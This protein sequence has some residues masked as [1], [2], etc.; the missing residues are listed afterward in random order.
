MHSRPIKDLIAAA[1]VDHGALDFDDRGTG[2]APRRLPDWTRAQLP[3]PMDV[4]VRMPSG[5]RLRFATDSTGVGISFLATTWAMPGRERRP[6]VFNLET[7]GTLLRAEST[8]GNAIVVK[9]ETPGGFDLVRGES[10]T[11]LFDG[12]PSG[13][14]TCELWLPHNALVE[15]RALVV[16]DGAAITAAPADGRR[17]WVHY[18]SSISHCME[19]SEPAGTWPAVAARLADVSLRN[20][21]FGGQCH[22]DQFVART[23]RDLQ[24]VDIVSIKTGINI[25]N[26]DSMRE[27]VFTPALHGF[28]DTIRERKPEVPI[29]VISPIYCP[30]AET[31]PG[32]TVPDGQGRF[33]TIDGFEQFRSGSLSLVR[34]R[35]II[36][37]VVEKRRTAGDPALH[38]VD[39]LTLFGAEDAHDLPD[40]LHPNPAGYRRMGE[41]F[42]PGLAE[43]AATLD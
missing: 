13:D 38:Y 22:L 30:S 31:R 32:P 9:P 5:V 42:A 43:L 41:R 37:D 28:L 4:T 2:L 39:G 35:E 1:A 36:A 17:R 27:R 20:L 34:I 12:L 8:S 14:K 33:V 25:V 15:L 18:G 16:D 7:D 3:Q 24:E 23:I 6:V 26:M 11:L 10:D 21:G 40:D 19:A 29:V